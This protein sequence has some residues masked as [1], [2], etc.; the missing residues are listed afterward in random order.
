VVSWNFIASRW[1][2]GATRIGDELSLRSVQPRFADSKQQHVAII[3]FSLKTDSVPFLA[4]DN[5]QYL[6]ILRYQLSL[7]LDN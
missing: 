1:F 4:S 2:Y 5:C 3:K 7:F 6:I